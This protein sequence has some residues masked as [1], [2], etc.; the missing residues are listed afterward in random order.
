[1]LRFVSAIVVALLVWAPSVV[2]GAQELEENGWVTAVG[3]SYIA[4]GG[5]SESSSLGVTGV[6]DRRDDRWR[7]STGLDG[8]QTEEDGETVSERLSLF[9]RGSR[10]IRERLAVTGGWQGERN[11]F[12]G[13]DFRSTF[14]AGV[15]WRA[16]EREEWTVDS[17]LSA[18]WTSEELVGLE[19]ENNLGAL[20]LVRSLYMFSESARSTQ[21][22]RFEPSFESSKDF[23][24]EGRVS[25]TSDLTETFALKVGA[26]VLYDNV[27]VP[28]FEKT[29]T[30]VTASLVWN[31][32]RVEGER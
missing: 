2:A 16:I 22:V 21:V 1:M 31:V 24:A 8:V 32:R 15:D 20:L 28:G 29:D 27:P 25:L 14:D 7:Y 13:V 12:A 26:A 5:N 9:A 4:T 6:W 19:S 17:I 30:T 11:R 18:T 10:E 3:L 23:R